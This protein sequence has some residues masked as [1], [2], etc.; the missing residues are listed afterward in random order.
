V[1]RVVCRRGHKMI[2]IRRWGWE[3]VRG[4]GC[5]EEKLGYISERKAKDLLSVYKN[6]PSVKGKSMFCTMPFQEGLPVRGI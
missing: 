2:N 4:A 6:G 1:K 3:E 5:M